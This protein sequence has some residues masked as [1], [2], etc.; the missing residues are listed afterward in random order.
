MIIISPVLE[1]KKQISFTNIVE[2]EKYLIGSCITTGLWSL[3]PVLSVSQ[4]TILPRREDSEELCS[5]ALAEMDFSVST[6]SGPAQGPTYGWRDLEQWAFLSYFVKH[7]QKSLPCWLWGASEK[8]AHYHP[9]HGVRTW[10]HHQWFV[11]SF[12]WGADPPKVE[13][14]HLGANLLSMII[15][16]YNHIGKKISVHF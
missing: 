6:D 2:Y 3:P 15:H 4:L 16:C 1:V 10:N 14:L 9:K 7:E 8:I 12:D 11:P 5:T 13:S